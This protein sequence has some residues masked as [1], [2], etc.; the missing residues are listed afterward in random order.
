MSASFTSAYPDAGRAIVAESE[1]LPEYADLPGLLDMAWDVATAAVRFFFFSKGRSQVMQLPAMRLPTNINDSCF[2]CFCGLQLTYTDL[3]YHILVA[4]QFYLTG[5]T[6]LLALSCAILA[7]THIGYCV[8]MQYLYVDGFT[9]SVLKRTLM[10]AMSLP[11]APLVRLVE[12]SASNSHY[13]RS[14]SLITISAR[15]CSLDCHHHFS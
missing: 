4:Q 3:W 6:T 15:P 2:D 13:P 8:L 5:H 12:N 11:F 9:H 10:F 14:A 7:V 1:V